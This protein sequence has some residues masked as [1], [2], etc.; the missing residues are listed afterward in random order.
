MVTQN[1]TGG[2][3]LLLKIA[4]TLQVDVAI[5]TADTPTNVKATA[6]GL[7]VGDL[8]A[9]SSALPATVTEVTAGVPYFVVA[10]PTADAFKISA[11]PGGS[12][13]TFTHAVTDDNGDAFSTLGGLRTSKFSFSADGIDITNHGS[14]QWKKILNGAGI[15]SLA[16]S[17]DGVY[18]NADNFNTMEQNAMANTL[19][20][21]AFCD[22]KQGKIYHGYFKVT[23]V[24]GSGPYDGEGTYSLSA[25]SADQ[26]SVVYPS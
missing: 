11:E 3:D 12:A 22:V 26:I 21:M 2:K 19:M 4:E 15:R 10:V 8:F 25:D 6:H 14:A 7:T 13:I 17:G 18:N 20:K 24:E 16:L 23:K 1:E 5:G 9:F